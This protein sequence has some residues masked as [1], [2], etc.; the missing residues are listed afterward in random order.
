MPNSK[1]EN[2]IWFI[3]SL[4]YFSK[5]STLFVNVRYGETWDSIVKSLL[6]TSE[7]MRLLI[8]NYLYYNEA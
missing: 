8:K 6:G 5:I 7:E 3:F 4:Y 1:D 2:N